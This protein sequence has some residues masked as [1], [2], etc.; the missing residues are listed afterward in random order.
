MRPAGGWRVPSQRRRLAAPHRYHSSEQGPCQA[1]R[2]CRGPKGLARRWGHTPGQVWRGRELR[3]LWTPAAQG[4]RRPRRPRA[5][6]SI[7]QGHLSDGTAFVGGSGERGRGE[8][9]VA[10]GDPG[11]SRSS[12]QTERRARPPQPRAPP[13]PT[14]AALATS[15]LAP[16][17]GGSKKGCRRSHALGGLSRPTASLASSAAWL[18][19]PALRQTEDPRLCACASR[20]ICPFVCLFPCQAGALPDVH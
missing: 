11:Q 9:E 1:A 15:M 3:R 19:W 8:C 14:T 7:V 13:A 17:F 6:G 12:M 2:G 10:A 20:R 5:C 16:P 18:S 4:R